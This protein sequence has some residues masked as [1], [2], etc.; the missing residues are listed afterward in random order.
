VAPTVTDEPSNADP[1]AVAS[2]SESDEAATVNQVAF[3][4]QKA[5][6]ASVTKAREMLNMSFVDFTSSDAFNCWSIATGPMT[7]HP[8][9]CETDT[10]GQQQT[11]SQLY[12]RFLVDVAAVQLGCMAVTQ[13]LPCLFTCVHRARAYRRAR[14]MRARGGDQFE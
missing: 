3:S 6:I 12:L 8:P 1:P 7:P 14:S 5:S 11:A 2:N 4:V 10:P 13:T 9:P